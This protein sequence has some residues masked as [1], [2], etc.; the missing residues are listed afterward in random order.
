MKRKVTIIIALVWF[1][2]LSG[3][4]AYSQTLDKIYPVIKMSSNSILFLNLETGE[5]ISVAVFDQP[6]YNV[7][8]NENGVFYAIT[9]NYMYKGDLKSGDILDKYKHTDLIEKTVNDYVDPNM[10]I[11]PRGVTPDG[12]ALIDFNSR[13]LEATRNTKKYSD[14]LTTE[15]DNAVFDI[16]AASEKNLK[17]FE[18]ESKTLELYLIDF[19]KKSKTHY[20]SFNTNDVLVG[21]ISQGDIIP[22]YDISKHEWTYKNAISGEVTKKISYSGFFAKHPELASLKM[23]D[24]YFPLPLADNVVK[25]RFNDMINEKYVEIAFNSKTNEIL[26]RKDIDFKG[27]GLKGFGILTYTNPEMEGMYY[28]KSECD[29]PPQPAAPTFPELNGTS[30]KKM[31]AW[32]EE[33]NKIN[34]EYKKKL[35]EW[36]NQIKQRENFCTLNIYKD[37]EM[38]QKLISISKAERG[39]IVDNNKVLITRANEVAL[40]NLNTGAEVWK[41]DTNF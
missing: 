18:K 32:Q 39:T 8:I 26:S 41:T 34:E 25:C 9:T 1:L 6:A 21:G 35:E 23:S 5:L 7:V 20:G 33:I 37:K 36:S 16:A 2:L 11:V 22:L 24:S 31:A 12:Y 3:L 10:Y 40:Y 14:K 30:A 29:F 28:P 13:K 27:F 4:N 38:A 17:V 15:D 19:N